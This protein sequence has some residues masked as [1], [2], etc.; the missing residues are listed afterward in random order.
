MIEAALTGFTKAGETNVAD[1]MVYGVWYGFATALTK[2][3]DTYHLTVT[4]RFSSREKQADFHAA[5]SD[6]AIE[7]KYPVQGIVFSDMGIRVSFLDVPTVAEEIPAFANWFF[8]LLKAYEGS[9]YQVCMECGETVH[10]GTWFLIHGYPCCIHGKCAD[11]LPGQTCEQ[12]DPVEA[13]G[14]IVGGKDLEQLPVKWRRIG[15]LWYVLSVCLGLGL[16]AYGVITV[17]GM[18]RGGDLSG[19]ESVL[20][21][22]LQALFTDDERAYWVVGGSIVGLVFL[23]TGLGGL[24]RGRRKKSY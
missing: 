23:L 4:T 16:I 20:G 1:G 7:A 17:A 14:R 18:F 6:A 22:I 8:P 13:I 21:L 11:R 19:G 10:E 15:H 3:A 2:A 5:I 9:G 24:L 12:A